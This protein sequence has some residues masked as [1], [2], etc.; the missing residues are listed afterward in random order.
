MAHMD[1]LLITMIIAGIGLSVAYLRAE[2]VVRKDTSRIA[3]SL[4]F[5]ELVVITSWKKEINMN[6]LVPR[7]LA[8]N[9]AARNT[10]FT[11]ALE[12]CT[13]STCQVRQRFAAASCL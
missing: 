7:A 1:D 12:T 9:A 2:L 8:V 4:E 10:D 3:D 13:A 11:A 5:Q 6:R